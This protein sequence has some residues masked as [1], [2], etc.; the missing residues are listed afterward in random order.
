MSIIFWIKRLINTIGRLECQ[1]ADT[2]FE[3]DF[4]TLNDRCLEYSTVGMFP[5]SDHG[6]RSGS[7]QPGKGVA[8]TGNKTR[9]GS[10]ETAFYLVVTDSGLEVLKKT[11]S[12]ARV[13]KSVICDAFVSSDLTRSL[14]F[15]NN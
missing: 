4:C 10:D 12:S 11:T 3:N 7:N 1:F 6:T 8:A 5:F 15:S 13:W 14:S 2:Q 9:P